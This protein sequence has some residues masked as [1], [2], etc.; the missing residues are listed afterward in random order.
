MV[1]L[2][3]MWVIRMVY[4]VWVVWIGLSTKL[5]WLNRVRK[6]LL[7]IM[8]G[9]MNGMV[10]VVWNSVWFRN[11]CWVSR[12][13]LGRVTIMVSRVD[14]VVCQIVNYV[15]FWNEVCFGRLRSLFRLLV[16]SF[17]IRIVFIGYKKKIFRKV[18]GMMMYNICVVHRTGF[19]LVYFF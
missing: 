10:V 6:V 9:R 17:W 2:K 7:I 8:V 18:L 13:V 11:W 16:F 1:M 12:W 14:I 5:K 15:I 3:K 19:M 4:M